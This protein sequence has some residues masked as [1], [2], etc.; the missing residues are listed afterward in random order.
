MK[1]QTFEEWRAV[2]YSYVVQREHAA[3]Q[4][5]KYQYLLSTQAE[6]GNV[7]KSL[8]KWQKL[9]ATLVGALELT[10]ERGV[11]WR[12]LTLELEQHYRLYILPGTRDTIA[13]GAVS[14]VKKFI[15]VLFLIVLFSVI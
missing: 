5:E 2:F 6:P 8:E 11:R 9:H 4:V 13:A 1:K 12:L 15:P 7:P 10:I 3:E 14:S